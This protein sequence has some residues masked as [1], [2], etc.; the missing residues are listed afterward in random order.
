MEQGH[1]WHGL[2]KIQTK[3]YCF[4]VVCNGL[5]EFGL[6]QLGFIKAPEYFQV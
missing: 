4:G 2:L 5:E 1:I 6:A 3:A